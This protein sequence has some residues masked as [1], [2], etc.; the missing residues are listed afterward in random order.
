MD[1]TNDNFNTL[2]K[3]KLILPIADEL[4]LAYHLKVCSDQEYPA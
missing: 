2:E 4:D 3:I 1:E